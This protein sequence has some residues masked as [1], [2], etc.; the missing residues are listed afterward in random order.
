MPNPF[1]TFGSMNF[2]RFVVD[3]LW[4]V[5]TCSIN[6]TDL[7]KFVIL[8]DLETVSYVL[9]KT[10]M[11]RCLLPKPRTM[12]AVYSKYILFCTVVFL[13]EFS[14]RP[15]AWLPDVVHWRPNWTP[16]LITKNICKQTS[17]CENWV[18]IKWTNILFGYIKA[19]K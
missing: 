1:C 19:W 2:I 16:A 17:D 8:S 7:Y 9:H 15:T 12:L 10:R 11:E 14:W 18:W 4:K 5:L 13:L 3:C 6:S